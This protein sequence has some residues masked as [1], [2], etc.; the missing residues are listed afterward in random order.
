M[1]EKLY[2]VRLGDVDV[3]REHYPRDCAPTGE[4]VEEGKGIQSVDLVAGAEVAVS[5]EAARDLVSKAFAEFIDD[6]ADDEANPT[7]A[8]QEEG[9]TPTPAPDGGQ[10][11]EG[12]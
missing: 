3:P 9:A 7:V 4:L 10:E 12:E 1:E 5:A 2:R 8:A 11:G 6:P